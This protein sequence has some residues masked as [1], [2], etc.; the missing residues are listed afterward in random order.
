[1]STCQCENCTQPRQPAPQR[2]AQQRPTSQRPTIGKIDSSINL[3]RPSRGRFV[4]FNR[5]RMAANR[6]APAPNP[7]RNMQRNE[8]NGR[9][10][11]PQYQEPQ[12][13]EQSKSKEVSPEVAA[14]IAEV[15]DIANNLT[16]FMPSFDHWD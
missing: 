9:G 4:A 15:Q 5:Q 16:G 7:Q 11:N 10:G 14:R 6:A 8:P 3:A 13:N 2:Q 1:M 12:G